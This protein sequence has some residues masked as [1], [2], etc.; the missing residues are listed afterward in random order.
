VRHRRNSLRPA[1]TPDSLPGVA[2]T[3]ETV[4]QNIFD[5]SAKDEHARPVI[6]RLRATYDNGEWT[7]EALASVVERAIAEE[8]ETLS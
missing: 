7:P 2:D 4:I 8:I 1:G 3:P 6:A 5:A